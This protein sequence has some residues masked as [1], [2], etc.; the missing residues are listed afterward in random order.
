VCAPIEYSYAHTQEEEENAD[1]GQISRRARKKKQRTLLQEIEPSELERGYLAEKDRQVVLEDRP[2]RYQLRTVPVSAPATDTELRDE[3]EWILD[4]AFPEIVITQQHHNE[5]I[6]SCARIMLTYGV[7]PLI[8]RSKLDEKNFEKGEL[9]RMSAEEK[10]NC[11]RFLTQEEKTETIR[12]VLDMIRVKLYE[13]PFIAFYRKE[14]LEDYIP[15]NDL[16]RI[17]AWDEKVRMAAH[18]RL[19]QSISSVVFADCAQREARQ[20]LQTHAGV[21]DGDGSA[22]HLRCHRYSANRS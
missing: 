3:A 6:V 14:N 10:D 15:I 16:W 9:D 2:E 20:S 11:K 22:T 13:V 7:Q 19:S 4:R 8:E 5:K 18:F 17:L 21:P 1:V 12:N